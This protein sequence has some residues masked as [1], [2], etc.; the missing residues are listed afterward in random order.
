MTDLNQDIS[1]EKPFK[2]SSVN[3]NRLSG[4]IKQLG[5]AGVES[6]LGL[7]RCQSLYDELPVCNDVEDFSSRALGKLQVGYRVDS[8]HLER[9]PETGSC[10]VV[11]NHPYGGIDGLVLINMI[12]RIRKDFKVMGNFILSRVPQ[13]REH[14]INVDPF[15]RAGSARTNIGPLRQSLRC[16]QQGQLLIVFPAGEVS[17]WKPAR[18]VTDPQWSLTVARLVRMSR[19]PVLPI[20]FPGANGPVFQMAGVIHPRLRTALLPK[21]LLNKKSLVLRPVIGNLIPTKKLLKRDNDKDMTELLRLKTYA[22]KLGN[23]CCSQGRTAGMDDEKA[24]PLVDPVPQ[25]ELVAELNGLSQDNR[26]LENG[27]SSVYV[28]RADEIPVILKEI[29]RLRE[30][31]FRQVGE[32][33][34]CSIDLDVYDEYYLHLFLWDKQ[35]QRI[36]GAYRIGQVDRIMSEQGMGGLYSSTLFRF[37]RQLFEQL[38]ASLELGRSFVHPDYQRSFSPLLMLW[39]GISAYLVRNPQYRYLFG[40]VSISADYSPSSRQFLTGT[41][42]SHY[43]VK[44]LENLVSARVPVRA[45]LPKVDGFKKQQVAPLLQDLDDL[46]LLVTDLEHDNKGIPVLMRHYLNLGGKLLAFNLDRQFSDVIDGLLLIDLLEADKKQMQR[47]MGRD[48]YQLFVANHQDPR[49][50]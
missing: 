13:L 43:K 20:Y 35:K 15:S 18:G 7:K 45:V 25:S 40:P 49:C 34:G 22:L 48:G 47:Y 36:I 6:L 41:L 38:G 1:V 4:R 42:A 3:Q 44:E 33:T 11:A 14:L 26:L 17:S 32:G 5:L 29:G 8:H 31:T 39:K 9:I 30:F 19:T 50:A 37:K 2:I 28:A 46:S 24:I 27:E 16:L 12:S 10:I 23:C 21:M